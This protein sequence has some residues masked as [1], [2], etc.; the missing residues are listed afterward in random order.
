M[1]RPN[2]TPEQALQKLVEG[3]NRCDT[4]TDAIN[5]LSEYEYQFIK[6]EHLREGKTE[7]GF[8]NPL[9]L[10]Y[11]LL[12]I[13]WGEV[14]R[15]SDRYHDLLDRIPESGNL[16]S[17]VRA[18]IE[19]D[20]TLVDLAS[21]EES[22]RNDIAKCRTL[23][24]L[25]LVVKK[26]GGIKYGGMTGVPYIAYGTFKAYLSQMTEA[27]DV[28]R[29]PDTFGFRDRLADLIAVERRDLR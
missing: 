23:A 4:L 29:F 15:D 3:V 5:L 11:F 2:D 13:R 19:R 26:Y 8:I 22:C 6:Y 12:P 17:A 21:N 20:D 10:C 28:D 18:V 14:T 24:D 25:E 9:T 1:E 16:Q 27:R 7:S